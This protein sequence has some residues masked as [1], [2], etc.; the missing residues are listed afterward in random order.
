MLTENPTIFHITHWKAGSQWIHKILR[1]CTPEIIIA[2]QVGEIQFLDQPIE[3]GKVYPTVYIT[4]EQ[5][6][7]VQLPA[8]WHRFI[9]IRDLRDTLISGY[10]S[11]KISHPVIASKLQ[12]WRERLLAQSIEDGLIYFMDEWLPASARIQQSWQAAGEPCIRY[13]DLLEQDIDILERVL[14][15]ECQL[16]IEH[17]RFHGIVLANRFERMTGRQRGEEQ[18][19][20]HERKGIAGDWRHYFSENVKS[21]FKERFGALLLATGYEH[22]LDW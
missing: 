8:S 22:D 2:P 19:T 17:T 4:K 21:A 1:C 20:A 12:A 11:V 7:S 10:F 15:D 9:V 13:E 18:V 5:F 14:L 16:P 3:P 6:D